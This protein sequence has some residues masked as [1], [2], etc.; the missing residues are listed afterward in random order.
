[1]GTFVSISSFLTSNLSQESGL[2]LSPWWGS[3]DEGW[4]LV[5]RHNAWDGFQLQ[6][7]LIWHMTADA[8]VRRT[9]HVAGE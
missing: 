8:N 6:T 1:M 5:A 4:L 7:L 9:V 3:G 2:S